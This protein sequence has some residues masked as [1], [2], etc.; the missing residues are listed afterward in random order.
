MLPV[1]RLIAVLVLGLLAG[2]ASARPTASLDRRL[3][4]ILHSRADSGA[5]CS[6]RVIDAES[7]R[8]LYAA[9]IDR[10]MIP[11][12]NL[13]LLVTS[14][15]LDRFGPAHAFTTRLALAGQDLHLIGGGDPATGDP[16]LAKA[17]GQTPTTLL[18]QW[19]EALKSAGVNRIGGDLVYHDRALDEQWIH[20]SWNRSF[21]TDWYAAPVSGL[22]FND[23]CV[24]ITVW[25]TAEGQPVAFRVMPPAAGIRIVNNCLSGGK[26]D[27]RIER[28]SD[29]N[30]YTLSGSADREA[31]LESKP[32][33][34]PGAFFAD[35]LRTH[36]RTRGMEVAG[37]IRRG[38]SVPAEMR[39]IATHE[40]PLSDVLW[41]I[42]KNSQNLFAEALAK[43]L[44]RQ[45]EAD[46]GR[47]APGSWEA[48][49]S[50][51]HAFLRNRGIDDSAIVVA[52]G[53]GLSRDNRVTA[54]AL[55]DLLLVMHRHP[56]AAEFRRSL[57]V[58]GRDGTLGKRMK[59]IEGRVQ[60][61]TGYIGGVRALSGYA[62]SQS[63]RTLIFSILFNEIPGDVKPFE[64]LQDR[65]CRVL[66]DHR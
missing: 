39:L 33:T 38:E 48:G 7:G 60:A 58:A 37:V 4:A 3:D 62:Q 20:P 13:K 29:A 32:V 41:R 1:A 15:A 22:N 26:H 61:K 27:P 66:I 50:A 21:L 2:C 31:E 6:A 19:A 52:D 51:V 30:V 11:A 59:D 18:D 43:L 55:T 5:I 49:S 45:F 16:R 12:S 64:E 54:R 47:N 17:R 9:D 57:S 40:T 23:N 24:D 10:P 35:V 46:N 8:E 25:P 56:H 36:L 53:S 14:A 44:G 34:D 65:A 63:G 28:A 42:N